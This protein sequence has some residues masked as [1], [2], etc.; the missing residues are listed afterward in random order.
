MDL[1]DLREDRERVAVE[2]H[3]PR[4]SSAAKESRLVVVERVRVVREFE[5][6]EAGCLFV[7]IARVYAR[8]REMPGCRFD[9]EFYALK[10]LED[11]VSYHGFCATTLALPLHAKFALMPLAPP[12]GSENSCTSSPFSG[13]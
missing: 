10:A 1:E 5:F 12:R 7:F 3:L 9:G 6:D 11:T 13:R 8:L 4:S 2:Q